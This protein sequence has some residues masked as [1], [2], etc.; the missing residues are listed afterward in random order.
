MGSIIERGAQNRLEGNEDKDSKGPNSSPLPSLVNSAGGNR[1]Y[2]F[3]G[4]S[5]IQGPDV[6][7][8]SGQDERIL[9][10][11]EPEIRRCSQGPA[12]AFVL[13]FSRRD[14]ALFN[15]RSAIDTER[16][17]PP[18]SIVL[19][20]IATDVKNCGYPCFEYAPNDNKYSI[21]MIRRFPHSVGTMGAAR[22]PEIMI[23]LDTLLF[24]DNHCAEHLPPLSHVVEV[25]ANDIKSRGFPPIAQEVDST[26]EYLLNMAE[27]VPAFSHNLSVRNYARRASSQRHTQVANNGHRGFYNT[28][29]ESN[30]RAGKLVFKPAA[31][32]P[33]SFRADADVARIEDTRKASWTRQ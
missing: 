11:M 26:L 19:G 7:C 9:P 16:H 6:P 27:A 32:E 29:Q 30:S 4:W 15:P 24:R 12:S 1:N 22:R 18:L 28:R 23:L 5:M 8:I 25:I 31:R 17:L 3:S 2:S 14:L 10:P 21:D 33:G 13:D 20:Q